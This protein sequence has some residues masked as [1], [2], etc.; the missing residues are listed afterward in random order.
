MLAVK[1]WERV[2]VAEERGGKVY[3]FEFGL[4]LRHGGSVRGA[5]VEEARL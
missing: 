1:R 4:R 3:L 2:W 5:F